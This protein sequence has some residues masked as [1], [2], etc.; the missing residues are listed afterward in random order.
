MDWESIYPKE[1]LT[2]AQDIVANGGLL[3]SE[4]PIGQ[5]CGRYGLVSR[6]RLQAGLAHATI[7]VQTGIKGG[8][9]HA[10]NATIASRKPLFV[11]EYRNSVDNSHEKVQGNLMLVREKGA[12]PLRS[13]EIDNA[14]FQI[15]DSHRTNSQAVQPTL[16]D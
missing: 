2:L 15:E 10:V 7:V 4:Y 9:M 13:T 12:F 14:V 16:F 6:D 11:V 1:N 5:S 8:T 3:L